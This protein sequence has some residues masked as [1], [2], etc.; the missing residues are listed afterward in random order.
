M[1]GKGDSIDGG[2]ETKC[3]GTIKGRSVTVRNIRRSNQTSTD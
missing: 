2:Y 1:T 3:G